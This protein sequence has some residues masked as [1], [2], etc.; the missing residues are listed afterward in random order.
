M[1]TP[2]IDALNDTLRAKFHSLSRYAL[3]SQP[4]STPE[5]THLLEALKTVAAADEVQA[6]EAARRI[7]AMQG[8][9][10]TGSPDPVVTEIA[11]LD[12]RRMVEICLEKKR[13][14]ASEAALRVEAIDKA[15]AKSPEAAEVTAF[16]EQVAESDRLQV[17]SLERA[18]EASAQ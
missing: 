18:L 11:Y 14:E 15:G 3:E 13:A 2:Y 10:V 9:P 17:E 8:I 16:L 4:Y 12:V 5:Q 7:E 1:L 6:R